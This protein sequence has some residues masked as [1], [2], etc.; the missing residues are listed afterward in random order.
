MMGPL[1]HLQ[2]EKSRIA[3]VRELHRVTKTD[4]TV[5]VAFR[6]RT[7]HI[8]FSLLEPE[9][10]KPHHQLENILRFMKTGIFNHQDEGRFTGAY[11][12]PVEDIKPFMEAHGFESLQ[13][14]GS[15]N[16]GAMLNQEQWDY[17][18]QR[19]ELDR[20]YDFLA[21]LATDPCILGVSSHLLYIGR[22]R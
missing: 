20:L 8:L 7:N 6:S 12:F 17:W 16:I 19:G 4:G 15:T 14:V 1:Y 22:K 13:L 18:R 2:D 3:A 5:F 9:H 21:E 11:F 10:W